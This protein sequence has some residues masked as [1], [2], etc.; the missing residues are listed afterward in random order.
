MYPITIRGSGAREYVPQKFDTSFETKIM[1]K[2][3]AIEII[4]KYQEPL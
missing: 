3:G 1:V 2:S 4:L